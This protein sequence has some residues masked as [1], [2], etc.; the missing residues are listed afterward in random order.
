MA[1]GAVDAL[2][3]R[4][5]SECC[6][7][8]TPWGTCIRGSDTFRLSLTIARY[9]L[10]FFGYCLIPLTALFWLTILVLWI[11]RESAALATVDRQAPRGITM[12]LWTLLSM[13]CGIVE[14][15]FVVWAMIVRGSRLGCDEN[16]MDSGMTPPGCWTHGPPVLQM[17]GHAEE[18][19]V[20]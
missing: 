20:T 6:G 12:G 5:C 16:V 9:V 18:A 3:R 2:E 1:L 14:G 4:T 8:Q 7:H 19:K 13:P 10:T 11:D 15:P 17:G